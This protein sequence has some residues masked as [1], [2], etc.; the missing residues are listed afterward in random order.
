VNGKDG[1]G[2][3]GQD[4]WRR[5]R[6][7]ARTALASGALLP[8]G[9]RHER[10]RDGA[11]RFVVRVVDSLARKDEA[12]EAVLR[13]R[14][15][16]PANPFLPYDPELWV[17]DVN[18]T[19]VC[20][21]NKYNVLEEHVLLV[22][23][24]FEEQE[25]LLTPADFE[26]LWICM[27]GMDLL[28]FYNGGKVA[29]ASQQHKHLQLVPVVG[30]G[31]GEELPIVAVMP[32][33]A[34]V[35]RVMQLAGLQFPH[36]WVRF[37]NGTGQARGETADRLWENYSMLL[38]SVGAVTHEGRPE[39]AAPYNLLVTRTWMMAVPRTAEFFAGISI[40]AL[41]FA[42]C[43]LVRDEQ[44]LE[45]V[46]TAGPQRILHDVTTTSALPQTWPP[47]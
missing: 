32:G 27:Q 9:T 17:A 21:L 13:G 4:L 42:G 19:H 16:R 37:E 38:R 18:A 22:T 28:A 29:G 39:Q 25:R 20:L 12:R 24:E 3:N 36:A 11:V 45:A 15:A 6:D 10:V 47:P 1:L 14:A 23:R 41:G 31:G 33:D 30:I 34:P 8:I 43:L 44:Q 2:V 40:N 5:V 26:A 35:G 7:T 46:R